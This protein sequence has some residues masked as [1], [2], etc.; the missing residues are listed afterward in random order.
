MSS[1]DGSAEALVVTAHLESGLARYEQRIRVGRHTVI[2][3]EP[4]AHGGGDSGASPTGLLLAALAGCTST[5]LR[6]YSD[7]KGWDLGT[8]K[9]D[10]KLLREGDKERID[11]TIRV[12]GTFAPEQVTRLLEIAD[13][14]PVTKLLKAG[15]Q[16]L[17]SL[18]LESA[19]RA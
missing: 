10:V 3:D 9:V 2:S 6:M 4:V 19:S 17:T 16:I 18:Q 15:V 12:Q 11:R 7:R 13:K 14:T 8:V 1:Q 5:T